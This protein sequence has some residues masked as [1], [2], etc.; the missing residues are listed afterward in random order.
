MCATLSFRAASGQRP[1]GALCASFSARR[2][3]AE[4][5]PTA[6]PTRSS[7]LTT[8]RDQEGA[9][10]MIFAGAPERLR[11]Q[12]GIAPFLPADLNARHGEFITDAQGAFTGWFITEPTGNDRFTPGN[13][14]HPLRCSTMAKA[15][16]RRPF[17][18]AAIAQCRSCTSA[19]AAGRGLRST[20]IARQPENP[21]W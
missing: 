8:R 14:L 21:S 3:A 9:G 6:T 17:A 4:L 20:A 15:A 5:P 12:H 19:P 16:P 7:S 2:P 13:T 1:A 10:N 11:P 18:V